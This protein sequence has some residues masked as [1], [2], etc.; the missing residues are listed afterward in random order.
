MG[1]RAFQIDEALGSG[2]ERPGVPA[3]LQPGEG[4]LGGLHFV[5]TDFRQQRVQR[6]TG[7]GGLEGI[8]EDALVGSG[9]LAEQ[10][11]ERGVLQQE[12]APGAVVVAVLPSVMQRIGGG[13]GMK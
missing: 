3:G 1:I 5:L 2:D 13:A 4:L 11:Q 8:H 10:G 6:G 7:R 12:K 9:S